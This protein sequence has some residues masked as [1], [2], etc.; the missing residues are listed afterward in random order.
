MGRPRKQDQGSSGQ[1]PFGELVPTSCACDAPLEQQ[2]AFYV[3][4]AFSQNVPIFSPPAESHPAPTI[5]ELGAMAWNFMSDIN[6]DNEDLG[7]SSSR[8]RTPK[9]NTEGSVTAEFA[10]E[11]PVCPCFRRILD[12]LGALSASPTCWKDS[13][14]TA[15][16]CARTV[17][18]VLNRPL[19]QFCPES[20]HAE[21]RGSI[22][23]ARVIILL[24]SVFPVIVEAY[25]NAAQLVDDEA[26]VARRAGR[27]LEFDLPSLGGLWGDLGD[28]GRG[29]E[30]YFVG[31]VTDADSW[32]ATVRALLRT[33]AYGTDI[34][35][36]NDEG[37]PYPYHHK[38]LW[39]F[40][41]DM[42]SELCSPSEERTK[43]EGIQ[44][45]EARPA[46]HDE[47]ANNLAHVFATAQ[48]SLKG[49]GI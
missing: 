18:E 20:H 9:M 41:E 3:S 2:T 38:G 45:W 11:E 49:L 22:H 39:D 33:D 35:H 40:A 48:S 17:Y 15:R 7:T 21:F 23:R 31:L 36:V 29:C 44:P 12:S 26:T 37:K 32:R 25:A 4:S 5:S 13:V 1:Q 34:T 6:M 24:G 27:K 30:R 46:R 19:C 16:Q 43:M 14:T 47:N 10:L 28:K 42:K 8:D